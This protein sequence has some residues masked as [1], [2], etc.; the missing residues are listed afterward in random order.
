MK[1]SFDMRIGE[2]VAEMNKGGTQN[3]LYAASRAAGKAIPK[4]VIP[5]LFKAAYYEYDKGTYNV[6]PETNESKTVE[7]LIPLARELHKKVR[8][9]KRKTE[10][11]SAPAVLISKDVSENTIESNT[12]ENDML[13]TQLDEAKSFIL[14][15]LDL[16]MEDLA[17]LKAM[18]HGNTIPNGSESI[19]ESIKQLGGRERVNKTY[20]I[21]KE[22][23]E[24]AAVFC[25][26]KS[27]KVSQFIEIAILDA[28]KKYQ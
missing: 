11:K 19:Y 25:E 6:T 26:D 17:S 14:R 12:L 9:E 24:K 3:M 8:D 15:A 23:I 7:E 22:I 18:A 28:M 16:T 27:V 13:P 4:D 5:Y 1:F 21:S 10:P 20:Y 2:L